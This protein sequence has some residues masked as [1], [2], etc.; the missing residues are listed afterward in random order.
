[1]NQHRTAHNEGGKQIHRNNYI[2]THIYLYNSRRYLIVSLISSFLLRS[3]VRLWVQR[4]QRRRSAGQ[5][6]R[7]RK[8]APRPTL[9]AIRRRRGSACHA[10][11]C[12]APCEYYQ[13]ALSLSSIQNMHLHTK[14]MQKLCFFL[15]EI[16]EHFLFRKNPQI[17][18]RSRVKDN[19]TSLNMNLL[20][21]MLY[22]N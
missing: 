3:S 10:P 5:R 22:L 13:L 9:R 18:Q 11:G 2:Y 15:L 7:G 19:F 21:P 1:M 6:K 8:T 12:H 20:F 16:V 14:D 4:R 17:F